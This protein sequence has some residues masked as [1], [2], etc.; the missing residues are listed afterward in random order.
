GRRTHPASPLAGRDGPPA[1]ANPPR[2]GRTPVWP[3]A[4]RRLLRGRLLRAAAGGADG[5]GDVTRRYPFPSLPRHPVRGLPAPPPHPLLCRRRLRAVPAGA[6]RDGLQLR[7][8][9]PA[10]P[11]ALRENTINP[12]RLTTRRSAILAGLAS[13]GGLLLPG[14]SK[15]L[16]P[17]Y[18]N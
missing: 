13:A 4:E 10:A 12:S 6:C 15:K 3:A 8:K 16:P 1:L 18:G 9:T 7:L 11:H 2:D 17:T 5:P 14:W